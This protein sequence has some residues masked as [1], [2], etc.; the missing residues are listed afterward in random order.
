MSHVEH[1]VQ[2]QGGHGVGSRAQL[3]KCKAGPCT[4]YHGDE[5]AGGSLFIARSL[6]T[7]VISRIREQV[8]GRVSFSETAAHF[9]IGVGA[10]SVVSGSLHT[11]V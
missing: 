5:R 2:G 4:R 6:Y 1:P 7:K 9:S 3:W 8:P 10:R 11:N